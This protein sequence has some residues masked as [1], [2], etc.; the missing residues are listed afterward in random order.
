[1][2]E[3][4]LQPF[5]MS[6]STYKALADSEKNYVGVQGEITSSRLPHDF[7]LKRRVSSNC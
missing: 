2:D 4:V 6:R 5:G 1:M 3:A 7:L